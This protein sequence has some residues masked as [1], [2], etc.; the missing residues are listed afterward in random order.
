MESLLMADLDRVDSDMNGLMVTLHSEQGQQQE[1][2]EPTESVNDALRRIY[3]LPPSV[4]LAVKFGGDDIDI[5]LSFE[6]N[7]VEQGA[8]LT[9][10]WHGYGLPLR[11]HNIHKMADS[12]RAS[13][14]RTKRWKSSWCSAAG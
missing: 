13:T 10:L 2:V 7:D 6:Q 4:P 9:V 5:S 11:A 3:H 14:G 1:Q 12:E 8:R